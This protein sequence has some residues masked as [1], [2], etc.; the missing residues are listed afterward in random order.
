MCMRMYACVC[1][2]RERVYACVSVCMRVYRS[3]GRS[4]VALNNG[5]FEILAGR[6]NNGAFG[7][8]LGGLK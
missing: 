2:C 8:V 3:S 7:Q 5:A 6:L 4:W 1:V